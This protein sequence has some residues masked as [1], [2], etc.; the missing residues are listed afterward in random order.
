M[1]KRNA[2]MFPE[3]NYQHFGMIDSAAS[4]A[5]QNSSQSV[6]TGSSIHHQ[7]DSSTVGT[8]NARSLTSGDLVHVDL[9]KTK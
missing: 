1:N 4:I 2:E 6:P 8:S 7:I 5:A 9:I 3:Q